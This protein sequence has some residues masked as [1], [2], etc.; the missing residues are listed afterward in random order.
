M[1]DQ[2]LPSRTYVKDIP[3]SVY[4]MVDAMYEGIAGPKEKLILAAASGAGG[5]Q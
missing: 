5:V 4:L 3:D 1:R 2:T